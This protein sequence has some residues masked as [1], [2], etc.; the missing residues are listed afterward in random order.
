M[1]QESIDRPLN[2]PESKVKNRETVSIAQG[3]EALV[4]PGAPLA[5]ALDANLNYRHAIDQ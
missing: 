1:L 3:D 4:V 2:Y 5:A